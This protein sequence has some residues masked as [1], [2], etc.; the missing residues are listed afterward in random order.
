MVNLRPRVQFRA[1]FAGA[2]HFGVLQVGGRESVGSLLPAQGRRKKLG[3]R[4]WCVWSLL[5][6]SMLARD[7]VEDADGLPVEVEKKF[8]LHE[9]AE[10][11]IAQSGL[12]YVGE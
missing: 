2:K 7:S 10:E 5:S 11:R 9:G 8:E 3:F 12:A 1:A 4:R 6:L